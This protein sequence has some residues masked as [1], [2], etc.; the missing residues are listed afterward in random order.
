MLV[1]M[2][3]AEGFWRGAIE[4]WIETSW[5]GCGG[6]DGCCWIGPSDC[7]EKQTALIVKL[8]AFRGSEEKKDKH[9][10]SESRRERSNALSNAVGI[11]ASARLSSAAGSDSLWPVCGLHL[12]RWCHGVVRLMEPYFTA[13]TSDFWSEG[14]FSLRAKFLPHTF[15]CATFC[16]FFLFYSTP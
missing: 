16:N 14:W 9:S 15:F 10:S 2:E 13:K 8:W 3:I 5:V 7:W 11:W 1:A 6:L 12:P 4:R